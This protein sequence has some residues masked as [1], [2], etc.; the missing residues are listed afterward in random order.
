MMSKV[1]PGAKYGIVVSKNRNGE[2][3]IIR[4]MFLGQTKPEVVFSSLSLNLGVVFRRAPAP[5]TDFQEHARFAIPIS[6][7]ASKHAKNEVQKYFENHSQGLIRKIPPN[8][9]S[10]Y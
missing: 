4:N 3:H 7:L 5:G 9:D 2:K 8:N 1:L 6:K 10:L